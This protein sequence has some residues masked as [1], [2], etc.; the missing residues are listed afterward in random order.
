MMKKKVETSLSGMAEASQRME[1]EE[2]VKAIETGKRTP[3][4]GRPAKAESTVTMSIR[5]TEA[6]KQKLKVYAAMHGTT[7]SDL[8]A[9]YAESLD[10]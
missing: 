5:I 2:N 7:I 1:K 8:I 3:G 4:R 9:E 10:I 6:R